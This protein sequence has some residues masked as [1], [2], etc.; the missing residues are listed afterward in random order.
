M[1]KINFLILL[2][3]ICSCNNELY[4]SSLLV[5]SEED[6][7]SSLNSAKDFLKNYNTLDLLG[8]ELVEMNDYSSKNKLSVE[9]FFND[10]EQYYVAYNGSTKN[11]KLITY[12]MLQK[13]TCMIHYKHDD[14]VKHIETL[15]TGKSQYN[16]KE[17]KWNYKN[18][19]FST[20][21]LFDRNTGELLYDNI[22]YNILAIEVNNSSKKYLNRGEYVKY[23]NESITFTYG[24]QK[25]GATMLWYYAGDYIDDPTWNT[26][27]NGPAP[28]V[29]H[30][31]GCGIVETRKTNNAYLFDLYGIEIKKHLS[32]NN[33]YYP[34]VGS[35]N[36]GFGIG[37]SKYSLP[38]VYGTNKY[39]KTDSIGNGY[40]YRFE[41]TNN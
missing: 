5:L 36:V 21:A 4:D 15:L 40:S 32:D 27:Q 37:G 24:G 38:V 2:I 39:Y 11:P 20:I 8:L 26:T 19:M 13:D 28:K 6:N 33:W 22:L 18:E 1:K 3:L 31:L 7:Y 23:V 29:Y 17:L 14:L 34:S 12:T 41:A 10:N 25:L 35:Y 30:S 16:V 9:D